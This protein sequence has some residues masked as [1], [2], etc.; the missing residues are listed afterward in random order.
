MKNNIRFFFTRLVV[1]HQVRVMSLVK[2]LGF[3]FVG[4]M[5][6]ASCS[7]TALPTEIV[8]QESSL[9]E[10][11]LETM[12]FATPE[13]DQATGIATYGSNVYVTGHTGGSLDGDHLGYRDG[14]LRR[15]ND[16]KVWGTQFGGRESD[17]PSEIAVDN[18]GNVYVSGET[19]SPLGFQVGGTDVLL[20]K[21]NPQ[22]ELLW[23]KQFGTKNS[24][25]VSDIAINSRNEVY[26]LFNVAD[27]RPRIKRYSASGRLLQTKLLPN[28]AVN[29][30]DMT[31]N[32]D[33]EVIVLY[34]NGSFIDLKFYK[35]SRQLNFLSQRVAKSSLNNENLYGQEIVTDSS[36][37]I[38]ITFSRWKA[39]YKGSYFV[40]IHHSTNQE[41]FERGVGYGVH[42]DSKVTGIAVDGN[43]V[44]LTGYTTGS[45]YG[46][47]FINAGKEDIIVEKYNTSGF[48][49][50]S[51]QFSKD[52][53]G[54]SNHDGALDIAIGDAVY[55]A[56]Y[57]N[58]NLLSGSSASHGD[59]DAFVA[60]L[61]IATGEIMGV[62]Q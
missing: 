40:K 21:Y 41:F 58:G 32:S 42:S 56:G 30:I 55:V 39:G 36:D 17:T 31:I 7:Q 57:T 53:Y 61:N 35:Y 48:R 2:Q 29:A 6:L 26:V 13:I 24:D 49:Q 62:D 43:F 8:S 34:N 52:N 20:M 45:I 5:V 12:D 44:Y 51:T 47:D 18:L 22:G 11:V 28:S 9:P 14:F 60:R 59:Y 38:Y 10:S 16:L 33:N 23:G 37:H 1:A 50:W 4:I 54:S 3:V 46:S 25:R 15:Y 27:E 19:R